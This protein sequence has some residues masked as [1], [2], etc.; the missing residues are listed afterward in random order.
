MFAT[1]FQFGKIIVQRR[2]FINSKKY[3][4]K[5]LEISEYYCSADLSEICRK[6]L[7]KFFTDEIVSPKASIG[8]IIS[9]CEVM[10]NINKQY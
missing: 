8:N 1:Y 6:E 3:F 7:L 2:E 5:L 9:M 4:V 10:T